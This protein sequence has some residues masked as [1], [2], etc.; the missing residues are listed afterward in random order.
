[1]YCTCSTPALPVTVKATGE[2]ERLPLVAVSVL[3][4]A[5]A[6]SVQLPTAAMPAALVV[7]AEPLTEPPPEATVKATLTPATGLLLMSV[8]MTLGGVPTAVPAEAD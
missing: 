1:L 8:T 4:P 3:A 2:P 6:P 7:A 5:V